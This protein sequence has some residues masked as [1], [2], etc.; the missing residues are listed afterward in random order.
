MEGITT[1]GYFALYI[2]A[3]DLIDCV[4]MIGTIQQKTH[5]APRTNLLD[6]NLHLRIVVKGELA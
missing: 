5:D 2:A 3:M 1:Q 4:G 6:R